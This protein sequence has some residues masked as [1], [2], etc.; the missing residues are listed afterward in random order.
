[1]IISPNTVECI[2]KSLC[3]RSQSCS[4]HARAP[5]FVSL[6]K[7]R[8][9]DF[10]NVVLVILLRFHR[11]PVQ[12]LSCFVAHSVSICFAIQADKFVTRIC[13]TYYLYFLTFFLPQIRGKRTIRYSNIR[14][15]EAEYSIRIC[16]H[17]RVTF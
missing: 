8:G 16:I 3:A 12:S 10:L 13:Q 7:G 2:Q 1:M 9:E 5:S 6:E 14:I 17:I 15:L 11:T 4:F